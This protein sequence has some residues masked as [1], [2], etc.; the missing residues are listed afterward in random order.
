MLLHNAWCQLFRA[1]ACRRGSRGDGVHVRSQGG[2]EGTDVKLVQGLW[3]S[4]L[5]GG[6]RFSPSAG[7][8][9]ERDAEQ[10]EQRRGER[11]KERKQE[12]R[13]WKLR[14]CWIMHSIQNFCDA[15]KLIS[16]FCLSFDCVNKDTHSTHMHNSN[17]NYQ[18]H[19]FTQKVGLSFHSN[20]EI[21]TKS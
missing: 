2:R 20:S 12:G 1:Y 15:M 13:S 5:V 21:R 10:E 17:N 8:S 7:W 16:L 14:S 19:Y 6:W 4:G 9:E 11:K 18:S 3:W